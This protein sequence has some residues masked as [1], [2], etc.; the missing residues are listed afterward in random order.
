VRELSGRKSSFREVLS[1]TVRH[2][3]IIGVSLAV[4]QQITGINTIIYYAPTAAQ[5]SR[6]RQLGRAAGQRRQ[7]RGQ[8]RH[9]DRR[10]PAAGP[11][12][13]APAA[14][15]RHGGAWPWA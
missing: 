9:D 10:D 6:A 13:P 2:V 1:P 3:M 5:G 15:E 11:H 8:R 12:G 7:R 14:A 4:F